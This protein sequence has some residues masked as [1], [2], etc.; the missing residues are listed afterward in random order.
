MATSVL[1]RK[2]RHES[3]QARATLR[4]AS[5]WRFGSMLHMA[6]CPNGSEIGT[7]PV[8]WPPNLS[9][10][11]STQRGH[12]LAVA[13]SSLNPPALENHGGWCPA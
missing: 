1:P 12:H 6:A 7:N 11:T 9:A 10:A 8:T 3:R 13:L 4:I 2:M 5:L